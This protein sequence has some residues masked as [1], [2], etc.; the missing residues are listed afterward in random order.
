MSIL[1]RILAGDLTCGGPAR[2]PSRAVIA[3]G[4]DGVVLWH[5]GPCLSAEIENMGSST[6][7][8]GLDDA[9][10]GISIWEGTYRWIPGGWEHPEDGET[11]P[12]GA[13]RAPTDEEWDAIKAGRA[14][15]PPTF[16]CERCGSY[17]PGETPRIVMGDTMLCSGCAK[18]C[19]A[20][21]TGCV[22]CG[23]DFWCEQPE[24]HEGSFYDDHGALCA[25][26]A[27]KD[28]P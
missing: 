6:G 19:S 5:T 12:C 25:D 2:E 21:V 1:D 10:K 22:E 28:T 13:F 23:A 18:D 26:H 4:R 14:P 3:M 11:E 17:E 15:W 24:G 16:Q 8:L 7:D 27:R 9:P 20:L